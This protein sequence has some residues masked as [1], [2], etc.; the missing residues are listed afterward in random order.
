MYSDLSHRSTERSF[1]ENLECL[2]A[3]QL[4]RRPDVQ[5]NDQEV[6]C[7]ICYSQSLPIGNVTERKIGIFGREITLTFY[8]VM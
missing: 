5:K 4:P 7:G 2:L 8:V 3:T 1:L 6:E